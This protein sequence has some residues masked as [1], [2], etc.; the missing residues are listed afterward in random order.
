M[1]QFLNIL[2]WLREL[3][4]GSEVQTLLRWHLS[5]TRELYASSQRHL[6]D[7]HA[8]VFKKQASPVVPAARRTGSIVISDTC[9]IYSSAPPAA[10]LASPLCLLEHGTWRIREA[11]MVTLGTRSPHRLNEFAAVGPEKPELYVVVAFFSAHKNNICQTWKRWKT[12]TSIKKKRAMIHHSTNWRKSM[13]RF[14][15][16]SFQSSF[17]LGM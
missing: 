10:P 7:Q 1:R 14:G 12:Q 8:H 16:L 11:E 3:G 17:S 9:K 6:L 2:V 5:A 15:H 4:F 13:N